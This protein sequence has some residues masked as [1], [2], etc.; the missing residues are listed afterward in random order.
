MWWSDAKSFV[1]RNRFVCLVAFSIQMGLGILMF[2]GLHTNAVNQMYIDELLENKAALESERLSSDTPGKVAQLKDA[3]QRLEE[4]GVAKGGM[5]AEGSEDSR[6]HELERVAWAA[7]KKKLLAEIESAAKTPATT[8]GGDASAE[9]E[10]AN[11]ERKEKQLK[12]ALEKATAEAKAAKEAAEAAKKATPPTAGATPSAAAE[13]SGSVDHKDPHWQHPT[14][15]KQGEHYKLVVCV[16]SARGHKAR[17]DAVR[18]TWGSHDHKNVAIKFAVGAMG[19]P[20]HAKGEWDCGVQKGDP[21]DQENNELT[22]QL[23]E[24]NKE[25]G[26]IVLVDMVDSYRALPKKLRL[27]YRY[28]AEKV[29]YDYVLKIDDDTY[30]NLDRV[31]MHLNNDQVPLEETWYGH[32]RCD[33]PRNTDGKWA[34]HKYTASNYPCF[35]GGGGNILTHDLSDWIGINAMHLQDYQGEDV[36]AGIWLAGRVHT[37]MPNDHF[38]A[39]GDGACDEKMATAPEL[40]EKDFYAMHERLTKCGSECKRCDAAKEHDAHGPGGN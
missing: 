18:K 33:W 34:E 28:L 32:M 14:I 35:G 1:K 12:D 6:A 25:H 26:D 21:N 2:K 3:L 20:A 23:E 30:V 7:E 16:L 13:S 27:F 40:D 29:N 8:A 22:K 38:H 39:L 4:L 15:S 11:W 9:K 37:R 10:K 19:C 24:E 36:S 31:L 5:K 17:R